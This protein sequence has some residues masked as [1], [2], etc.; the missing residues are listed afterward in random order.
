VPSRRTPRLDRDGGRFEHCRVA[1]DECVAAVEAQPRAGD[2]GDPGR[3]GSVDAVGDAQASVDPGRRAVVGDLS[4]ALVERSFTHE[5]RA[6]RWLR[7][8]QAAEHG[9]EQ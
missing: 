6:Y 3:I 2:A 8:G 4:G 5:C 9:K 7:D 1:E